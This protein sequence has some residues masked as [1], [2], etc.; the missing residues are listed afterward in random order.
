MGSVGNDKVNMTTEQDT[1]RMALEKCRVKFQEYVEYNSSEGNGA[2][3]ARSQDM[4]DM[5]DAA[6]SA[7]QVGF[8]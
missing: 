7:Q 1:L 8:V 4:V 2:D 6:L 3:E 5:I